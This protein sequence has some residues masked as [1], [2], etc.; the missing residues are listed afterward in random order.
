MT[1]HVNFIP[2]RK[3]GVSGGGGGGGQLA[4][5]KAPWMCQTPILSIHEA[6]G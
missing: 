5:V 3:W 6:V 2:F 4:T 1:S